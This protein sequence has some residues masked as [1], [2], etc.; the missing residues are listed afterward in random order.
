MWYSSLA[1]ASDEEFRSGEDLTI[2]F[3]IGAPGAGKGTLCKRFAKEHSFFHLSVGDHLRALCSSDDTEAEE[4]F[5]GISQADLK[6]ALEARQLLGA[7]TVVRIVRYKIEYEEANGWYDFV[8]DGF[9][10]SDE[11][12]KEFEQKVCLWFRLLPHLENRD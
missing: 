6:S 10:R 4:A 7:I 8:V 2:V 12:A 11:S 3:V 9:P 1:M 5:G